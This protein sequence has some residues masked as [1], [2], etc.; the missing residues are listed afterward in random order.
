MAACSEQFE[1]LPIVRDADLLRNIFYS[2][3]WSRWA[4]LHEEKAKGKEKAK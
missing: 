4:Y 2:G 3:V 1:K